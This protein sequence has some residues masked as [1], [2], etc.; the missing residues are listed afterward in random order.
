MTRMSATNSKILRIDE[1]TKQQMYDLL[2]CLDVQI[3]KMIADGWTVR[4][5]RKEYR[6]MLTKQLKDWRQGKEYFNSIRIRAQ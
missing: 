3:E 2:A 1:C 5:L 6:V 4:E